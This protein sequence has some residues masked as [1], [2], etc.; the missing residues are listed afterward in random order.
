MMTCED[1][2]DASPDELTPL[3]D[4]ERLRWHRE[5]SWDLEPA[6]QVVRQARIA[7]HL[8][9]V[10]VRDR[11]GLPIGWAFYVLGQGVLQIGALVG[12]T[13]ASLRLMLD[14]VFRSPESQMAQEL[15]CF[16]F[17]GSSSVR[18]ALARQRF[19]LHPHDYMVVSLCPEPDATGAEPP[20][21]L[22]D[23]RSWSVAESPAAVRLMARAYAGDDTARCFS[24]HGRLDEWA[25]YLGQLLAGPGC[26]TFRPEASFVVPSDHTPSGLG[27]LVLTTFVAPDTAHIAQLVIDPSAQGRGMG[28]ALLGHAMSRARL[29]GASRLTLIVGQSNQSARALYTRLG[30]STTATFLYGRRG[31]APRV[32]DAPPVAVAGP[33]IPSVDLRQN[34]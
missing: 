28:G 30:F 26:G 9:G 12:T 10:L 32:F 2:R 5:L 6:L 11:E 7:G 31:A 3:F 8:P 18:A 27:G 20:R 1:W 24:P 13:A 33:V 22:Q 16:L 4:A 23:V 17:P 15:S 14:R 25:H 19:V 29:A 34:L 21:A